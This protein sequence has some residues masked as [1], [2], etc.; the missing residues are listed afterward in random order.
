MTETQLTDGD[1]TEADEPI[2]LFGE[3]LDD[4]TKSEPNDPTATALATVDPDGL[5]N[6]RMVL[7][8]DFDERGF[9]FYTNFESAKGTEILASMKAAMCFHWKS[10]RRQVRVRGAVEVVTQAEAD[11]YFESRPRGSRIGAW[12]SKQSRPLETRFALEKAVAEYTT[13][14][15][16]GSIP[17]PDY[18]SGFRIVPSEIEFWHDRPFRLHDRVR[19][20]REGDG[21]RKVRL[22]P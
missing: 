1:F 2:R 18:W 11:A 22:Y 10:L 3:W 17:R 4:A 7:L 20:E 6:V 8:K 15:A 13:R 14:H 5:P 9:V 21:W 19:F 12:A 16:I